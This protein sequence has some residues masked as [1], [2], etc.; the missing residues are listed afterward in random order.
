MKQQWLGTEEIDNGKEK[1]RKEKKYVKRSLNFAQNYV[2]ITDDEFETIAVYRQSIL[3]H[4]KS[5]WVKYTNNVPITRV[6]PVQ[7]VL[8]FPTI[9]SS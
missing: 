5:S 3:M 7:K 8:L 1:E 6:L 4:N 9:T 2:N